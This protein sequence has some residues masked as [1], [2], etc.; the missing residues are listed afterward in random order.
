MTFLRSWKVGILC[1]SATIALTFLLPMTAPTP[2]RA[3]IRSG[4]PSGSV[5]AMPAIRPRYSPTGLQS[6]RLTLSP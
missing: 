5:K 6:A 3:A 2:P 4:R 1:F